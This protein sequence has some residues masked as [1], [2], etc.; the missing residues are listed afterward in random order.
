MIFFHEFYSYILDDVKKKNT[1][2]EEDEGKLS[3]LFSGIF[4]FFGVK[5]CE[6]VAKFK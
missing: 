1:L 4:S 3:L 2:R 5:T 6:T